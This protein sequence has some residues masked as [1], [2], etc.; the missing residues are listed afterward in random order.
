MRRIILAAIALLLA[1]RIEAASVIVTS[2]PTDAT[3]YVDGEEMGKTPKRLSL[4]SGTY[5]LK[6]SKEGYDDDEQTIEVGRSLLRIS[7]KLAKERHPID[8]VFK[9]LTQK[10][11]Y[12]FVNGAIVMD[13]PE[14][15]MAPA[16]ID[17]PLGQSRVQLVKP[18]FL[19]QTKTL[20][21]KKAGQVIEFEDPKKGRSSSVKFKFLKYV[22]CWTHTNSAPTKLYITI[23]GSYRFETD[24]NWKCKGKAKQTKNG[25]EVAF[26]IEA[27]TLKIEE[28]ELRG[29]DTRGANWRLRR[30]ASR[31]EE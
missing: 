29:K 15:A 8:I 2:K 31:R 16:T 26:R 25:I 24:D 4:P 10:G 1:A 14:A 22:G 28:G 9:D 13:G 7:Q 21:I 27:F 23:D 18:G 19:D 12:V 17:L 20:D 6:L 3:I 30:A 11:W 5:P